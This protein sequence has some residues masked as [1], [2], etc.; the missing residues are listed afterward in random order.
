MLVQGNRVLVNLSGMSAMARIVGGEKDYAYSIY[1]PN[2]GR[3]ILSRVPF[4]GAAEGKIDGSH[5]SFTMLGKSY[6]LL[7]GAP[8]ASVDRVWVLYQAG[9][10]PSKEHIELADDQPS[11]TSERL[12][13]LLGIEKR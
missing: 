3:I 13:L 11:R 10:H 1:A 4:E 12:P 9:W 6:L 8:I 5:I 2:T 7:T